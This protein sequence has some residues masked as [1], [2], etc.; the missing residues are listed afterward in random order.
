MTTPRHEP[1][2]AVPERREPG[3]GAARESAPERERDEAPVTQ[4]GEDPGTLEPDPDL[5]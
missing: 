3:R 5:G 2:E 4:L 1:S